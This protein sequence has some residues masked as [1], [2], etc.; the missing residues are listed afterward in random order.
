MNKLIFKLISNL[1]QENRINIVTNQCEFYEFTGFNQYVLIQS[2]YIIKTKKLF[3][4]VKK[5]YKTF[6]TCTN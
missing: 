1:F 2:K 5:A 4:T 6:K 3:T